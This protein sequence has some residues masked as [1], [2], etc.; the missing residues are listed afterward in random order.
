MSTAAKRVGVIG[1][2][3]QS[4]EDHLPALAA[5]ARTEL[6]ALCDINEG[7]GRPIADEYGVPFYSTVE[8]MLKHEQLDFVVVAVPHVVHREVTEAA[9]RAGVHV[10]KEKPFAVSRSDAEYLKKLADQHDI[11]VMTTLQRRFNPTYTS[12]FQLAE[13][14]GTPFAVD[15]QYT[16]GVERPDEGWRGQRSTAGGGCLIDMG[17]HML[18]L[19]IWYLGLPDRLA[20]TISS[21]AIPD[22]AYDAE[23]TANVLMTWDSGLHGT[24]RIS[25]AMPPKTERFRLFA[26]EGTIEIER[27]VIR[28]FRK[29][30]ELLEELRRT[31]AWS[32][33]AVSQVEY[34]CDVIDGEAINHGGPEYHLQHT[35]FIDAA[36]RAAL[37]GN[38]VDLKEV[39]TDAHHH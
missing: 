38:V 6:V 21:Q 18:D 26:T 31:G 8:S 39:Q 25:R 12:Y 1:V 22:H 3:H 20:A 9:I 19:L 34:F 2:G 35:T 30:G 14:I 32:P 33:A 17:Y 36:Y 16:L 15:I 5:S 10:L 7:S 24:M 37:T 13:Q 27:G 29:D 23:D 4:V 28:R 11:Q